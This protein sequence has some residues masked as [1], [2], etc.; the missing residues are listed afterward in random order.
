MKAIHEFRMSLFSIN[1]HLDIMLPMTG[2]L[3]T[4]RKVNDYLCISRKVMEK[5][6]VKCM[7]LLYWCSTKSCLRV[8]FSECGSPWVYYSKE[9]RGTRKFIYLVCYLVD[10]LKVVPNLHSLLS[11]RLAC[12]IHFTSLSFVAKKHHLRLK[13]MAFVGPNTGLPHV[14]VI[15]H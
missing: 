13:S 14:E 15:F 8:S 4:F 2:R 3:H 1:V 6:A 12:R 7:M 5:D 11:E 10:S 9:Q